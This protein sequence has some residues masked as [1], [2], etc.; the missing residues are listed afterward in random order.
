M[1]RR[2]RGETAVPQTAR[3][4]HAAFAAPACR[5]AH[6]AHACGGADQRHAKGLHCGLPPCQERKAHGSRERTT[7]LVPGPFSRGVVERKSDRPG[8]AG[9]AGAGGTPRCACTWRCWRPRLRWMSAWRGARRR[10]RRRRRAARPASPGREAGHDMIL[11][12]ACIPWL[13]LSHSLALCT[14]ALSFNVCPCGCNTAALW[15]PCQECTLEF[16]PVCYSGAQLRMQP[17]VAWSM[18]HDAC[19][20]DLC[21]LQPGEA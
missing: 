2:L 19:V 12:C 20:P 15:V 11:S 5:A 16:A 10:A 18:A 1:R 21:C 14:L 7:L 6:G 9:R 13:L 8:A 3:A 17:S 4:A